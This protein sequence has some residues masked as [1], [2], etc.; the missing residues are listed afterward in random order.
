MGWWS[1]Q[2]WPFI[3]GLG[4]S[5]DNGNG[6]KAKSMIIRAGRR[7]HIC[8][9][10][11]RDG[12]SCVCKRSRDEWRLTRIHGVELHPTITVFQLAN[13]PLIPTNGQR[14]N[15][16]FGPRKN[17]QIPSRVILDDHESKH[18]FYY[19]RTSN[20]SDHALCQI[21]YI[22]HHILSLAHPSDIL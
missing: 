18:L 21:C 3:A 11:G 4:F 17:D 5:A 13:N 10:H 12:T 1:C 22:L 2:D 14:A 9:R 20:F 16:T 19:F 7:A 6:S 8:C 15:N